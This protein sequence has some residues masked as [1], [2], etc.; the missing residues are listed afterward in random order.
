MYQQLCQQYPEPLARLANLDVPLIIN[1]NPRHICKRRNI[2][3]R[4]ILDKPFG[5]DWNTLSKTEQAWFKHYTHMIKIRMALSDR[6]K[7]KLSSEDLEK[8]YQSF[9]DY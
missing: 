7:R 8:Y 3:Q 2:K 4:R 1:N 5:S 9:A 6:E